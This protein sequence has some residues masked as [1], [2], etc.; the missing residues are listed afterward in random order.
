MS[1]ASS[2]SNETK[3]TENSAQHVIGDSNFT[4]V[5]NND[6]MLVVNDNDIGI[7]VNAEKLHIDDIKNLLKNIWVPGEKYEFPW[8]YNNNDKCRKNSC[9]FNFSSS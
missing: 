9:E 5:H 8:I 3:K 6:T 4:T 7:F 2:D 1:K